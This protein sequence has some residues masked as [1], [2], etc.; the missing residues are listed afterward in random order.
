MTTLDVLQFRL[1]LTVE[2]YWRRLLSD[3]RKFRNHQ[4]FNAT[5]GLYF[6]VVPLLAVWVWL[7]VEFIKGA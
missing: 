4:D 5:M 6:G 3:A 1:A 7:L 2:W